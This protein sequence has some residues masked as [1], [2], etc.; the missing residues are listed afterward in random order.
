M[1]INGEGYYLRTGM[2]V[3]SMKPIITSLILVFIS[4]FVMAQEQGD[5]PDRCHTNQF[6]ESNM[7]DPDYAEAHQHKMEELRKWL[8]KHPDYA[9]SNCDEILYIPVAVHFQ[10]NDDGSDINIDPACAE[11]MALSQ[12]DAINADF[13]AT[14]TDIT[15][16]EDGQGTWPDISNGS[17]C[18]QFCLATLDHPAGLG[19]TNGDY[20]ITINEYDPIDNLPDW[21]GYM[22]WFVR[23]ITNPL[24]YSPLGGSGNGDGVVCG[25]AYFGTSNC[26]GTLSGQYNL[27]RTIT[28]EVGH[29][30]SLSHPFDSGDCVTDGDGVA[31]TPLTDEATYGCFNPGESF[32][33]CDEPVLWPTYMEYCDD[34][35]L[36][37]WTE[38]QV[39]QM[40]GYV[41]NSLTNLI[42]SSSSKCSVTAC[43]DF[44]VDVNVTDESCLNGEDG[45]IELIVSSG[46][47]PILYSIDGGQTFQDNAIFNSL[48]EDRYDILVQDGAACEYV[49]SVF[50]EREEP[51]ITILNV[52][53]AFCEENDGSILA[54]VNFDDE[55]EYNIGSGW[56]DTAFFGE[57]SADTYELRVRNETGCTNSREVVVDDETDLNMTINR[58]RPV[59]CPLFDNGLISASLSA[60]VPPFEYRLN[61]E[62][63]QEI[64]TYDNLVPGAYVLSVEDQR[65]CKDEYEFAIQVSYANIEDDCPCQVFIPNAITPDGDERNNAFKPVPSCPISDY[66]LQIFNRWGDL[67]FETRDQDEG[68]AGGNDE[69]YDQAQVY[70]YRMTYRWGEE[71]NESLEL[72][73]ST[74]T[75]TVLR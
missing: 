45:S 13:N 21:T 22:N 19:L 40:D 58:V 20:A 56:Q 70:F 1:K 41:N 42:N 29:Y 12:I 53:N 24:G 36:Y 50:L 64:G 47:N 4:G 23:D 2:Q 35:C 26:N 37:M 39:A 7:Q 44:A 38:E 54:E 48:E 3:L 62:D 68:W 74:G 17:S 63:P 55:F 46:T 71:Q 34:A 33:N 52:T 66:T 49:D 65:G 28:H 5:R 67:V 75:I 69:Y 14:N 32:V 51:P 6:H 73:I 60:G 61:G 59:N 18:V 10:R 15:N 11:E 57:L 25:L 30:L 27:G 16:W 9:K 8:A 43:L 31:D 72:Q